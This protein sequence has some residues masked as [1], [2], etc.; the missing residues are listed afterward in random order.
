MRHSKSLRDKIIRLI[1]EAGPR[2]VSQREIVFLTGASKGYVSDLMDELER[3]GLVVRYRGPG[4]IVYVR[5]ARYVHPIT[6]KHI[7]IGVVRASEYVFIPYL[8]KSLR[9]SGYNVELVVFKRVLDVA[10]S[11]SRGEIHMGMIPVYTQIGYRAYGAPIKMIPGG[12][13]GGGFIASRESLEEFDRVEKILIASS[14]LST[15]EVLSHALMR[16][17][18]VSYE[19]RYYTEPSEVVEKLYSREIHAVSVW[20]PYVSEKISGARDLKITSFRDLLGEYHCCTLAIHENLMLGM[21]DSISRIYTEAIERSRRNID[22]AT[23]LYSELI[24]IDRDVLR[25]SLKEYHFIEQIDHSMISRL[26][27]LGGGYMISEDTLRE[28]VS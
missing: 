7:R 24:G 28:L 3:K 1:E 13:L 27:K 14:P 2:G 16:S 5:H 25:K 18:R 21:Y 11:L 20:E 4:R 17:L 8:M 23:S 6:G 19:I 15:M 10:R 9:E 26:I 12:A 22:Q